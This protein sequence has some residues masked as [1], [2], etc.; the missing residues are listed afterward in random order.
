VDVKGRAVMVRG[1]FLRPQGWMR[2]RCA[3]ALRAALDLGASAVPGQA[4]VGQAVPALGCWRVGEEVRAGG[5]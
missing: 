3:T 1:R 2:D 4:E 5:G